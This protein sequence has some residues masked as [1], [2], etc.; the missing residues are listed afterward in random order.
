MSECLLLDPA[1]FHLDL[2]NQQITFPGARS[3]QQIEGELFREGK[4]YFGS[5][6]PP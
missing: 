4:T 2:L 6:P 5:F 3:K 1:E